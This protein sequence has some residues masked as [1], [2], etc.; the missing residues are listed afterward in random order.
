MRAA[1][2]A[3]ARA[4]NDMLVDDV[5][6]DPEWLDAWRRELSDLEWFLVGVLA[7]LE[8]LEERERARGNRIAGE[9][10]A[11]FDVIHNGIEYD[12]VVDSARQSPQECA[13]AIIAMLAR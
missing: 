9:A 4:G 6:V 11:Q 10:R 12:L 8:V 13:A 2:A 7:P 5:F 3:S 1:V